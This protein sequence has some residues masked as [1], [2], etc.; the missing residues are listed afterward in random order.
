MT[1][2]FQLWTPEFR[3]LFFGIQ[4]NGAIPR[5]LASLHFL[6]ELRLRENKLAGKIPPLLSNMRS[7]QVHAVIP[8]PLSG[9]ICV[10]LPVC[11]FR[12]SCPS[13]PD[14]SPLTNKCSRHPERRTKSIRIN[15]MQLFYASW[16]TI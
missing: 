13:K 7:L 3:T 4:I 6:V 9:N 12:L 2:A 16:H 8:D 10:S 11:F 15:L 1:L 5:E 14:P